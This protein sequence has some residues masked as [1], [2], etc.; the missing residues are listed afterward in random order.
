MFFRGLITELH[1][2]NPQVP[3]ADCK[4]EGPAPTGGR[5][6]RQVAV[7]AVEQVGVSSGPDQVV[8][9]VVQGLLEHQV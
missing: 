9:V 1:K 6:G 5:G 2:Y 4:V 3:A 7:Q 8:W